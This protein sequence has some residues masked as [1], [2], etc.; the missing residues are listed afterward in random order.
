[1]RLIPSRLKTSSAASAKG[2]SFANPTSRFVG[3]AVCDN[4]EWINGLSNPISESY[5]PNRTGHSSGYTPRVSPL[6][7][8]ATGRAPE[9]A[10]EPEAGHVRADHDR[11]HA[12]T[13]GVDRELRGE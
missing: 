1:M 5:H 3:H 7:T 11:A 2:F 4:V 9:P 13:D 10:P 6:L 8:G 12:E